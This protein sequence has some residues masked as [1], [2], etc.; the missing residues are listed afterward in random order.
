MVK[1]KLAWEGLRNL[2]FKGTYNNLEELE[3]WHH[4][5]SPEKNINS[6]SSLTPAPIQ[7]KLTTRG[8]LYWTEFFTF[9]S[10]SPVFFLAWLVIR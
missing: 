4:L 9:F 1:K 6:T 2:H 5:K 3:L 10:S 8:I 7:I